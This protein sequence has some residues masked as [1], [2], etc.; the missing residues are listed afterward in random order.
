MTDVGDAKEAAPRRRRIV[1]V[2]YDVT[3]L[4]DAQVDAILLAL[5]SS[6]AVSFHVEV[7]PPA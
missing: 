4:T 7:E 2:E 5:A 6:R 1:F 3:E